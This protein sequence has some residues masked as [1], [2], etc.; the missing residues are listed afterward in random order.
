MEE[1][2]IISWEQFGYNTDNYM[3]CRYLNS[4]YR[5]TLICYDENLEK[6]EAFK[7]VEIVY[8][9][10]NYGSKISRIK[11]ILKCIQ[12]INKNDFRL[13]FLRYFRGC[14]IFKSLYKNE[15]ILVDIRTGSVTIDDYKRLK[16]N[17]RIEKEAN[18]FD[19]ITVI[20]EGLRNK[21]GLSVDKTY[22]LPLGA[23]TI[24]SEKSRKEKFDNKGLHFL[25]IGT[26]HNRNIENTIIAFNNFY[27]KYKYTIP[28]KYTIA[29]YSNNE[30]EVENIKS[31]IGKLNLQNVVNYIGRVKYDEI[32]N[33]LENHNVGI[34]Y[35]PINDIYNEQPPTKTYEYILNG[36]VCVGTNTNENRKIINKD[37]GI[38]TCDDIDSI[39]NAFEQV[40]LNINKYSKT[41]VI[42]TLQNYTWDKIVNS[43]LNDIINKVKYE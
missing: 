38:L 24:I 39:S 4:K 30:I 42:S 13:I 21:L 28:I 3:Y 14:S 35:I 26:F 37:N 29:G 33:L 8:V 2:L 12:L 31:T 18:K 11:F 9:K 41:K 27:N 5:V 15:K 40:C 20:S 23:D 36:L 32:S 19:V 43:I 6:V 10:K 17:K 25:Y 16:Y 22:I 34:S 1:I 7:N